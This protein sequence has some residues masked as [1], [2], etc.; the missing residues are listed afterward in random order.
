MIDDH[1][2]AGDTLPTLQGHQQMIKE[3]EASM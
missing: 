1:T 2:K 3:I